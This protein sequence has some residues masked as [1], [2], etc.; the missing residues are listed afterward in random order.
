MKNI[1]GK[2]TILALCAILLASCG[3]KSN[4]E[5]KTDAKREDKLTI[6]VVQIADHP[7]LCLINP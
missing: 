7:C 5:S 1:V 6:G 4:E 2:I 3:A